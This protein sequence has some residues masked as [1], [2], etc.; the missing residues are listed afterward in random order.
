MPSTLLFTS[1]NISIHLIFSPL[2][3]PLLNP[4]PAL[5]IGL[6]K[7]RD[8]GWCR[9]ELSKY[10][11]SS[12]PPPYIPLW[13]SVL[14]LNLDSSPT[15]DLS[16]SSAMSVRPSTAMPFLARA[17]PAGR[18]IFA[19]PRS[20]YRRSMATTPT[21]R[22]D[23]DSA[24]LGV[25]ELQGAKFRIE[26]LRRVGEDDETKRARLVC[27]SSFSNPNHRSIHPHIR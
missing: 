27:T 5:G 10:S 3:E 24:E 12:T 11:R 21:L 17:S 15:F 23:G 16:Q 1:C 20:L 18:C 14:S 26:P 7:V 2:G 8:T 25:G 19:A 9:P 22:S 13:S 4:Y 6:S